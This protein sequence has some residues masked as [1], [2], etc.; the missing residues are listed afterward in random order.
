MA[1]SQFVDILAARVESDEVSMAPNTENGHTATPRTKL[2][3]VARTSI[4]PK[5][6]GKERTSNVRSMGSTR[7]IGEWHLA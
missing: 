7:E 6:V 4:M 2:E 3:K 5:A 1:P